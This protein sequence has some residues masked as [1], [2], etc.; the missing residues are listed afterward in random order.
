MKGNWVEHSIHRLCKFSVSL[1]YPP[2]WKL[3]NNNRKH[4]KCTNPLYTRRFYLFA[5][6][7]LPSQIRSSSPT[8]AR[9]TFHEWGLTFSPPGSFLGSLGGEVGELPSTLRFFPLLP[10]REATKRPAHFP[11]EQGQE[12]RLLHSYS[13]PQRY[14]SSDPMPWSAANIHPTQRCGTASLTRKSRTDAADDSSAAKHLLNT[15]PALWLW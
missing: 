8:K 2:N 11:S 7:R 4:F 10:S 9:V 5:Q 15:R 13:D 14:L 3:I 6:S 1:K 12:P